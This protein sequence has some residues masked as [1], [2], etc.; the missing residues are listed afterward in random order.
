MPNTW[1]S[2]PRNGARYSVE[3]LYDEQDVVEALK[4]FVS[5]SYEGSSRHGRGAGY[6]RDVDTSSDR[7]RLRVLA[8]DASGRG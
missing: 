8:K 3:A 5:V 2:R 4:G 1:K 6:F 7:R